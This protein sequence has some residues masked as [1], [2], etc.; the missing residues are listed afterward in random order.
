VR[1]PHYPVIDLIKS[2]GLYKLMFNHY[3]NVL[4]IWEGS[5]CAKIVLEVENEVAMYV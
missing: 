5:A 3:K 1:S 2:A 4:S